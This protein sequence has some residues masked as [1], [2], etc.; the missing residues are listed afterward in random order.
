MSRC[1]GGENTPTRL[2]IPPLLTF[3]HNA[4]PWVCGPRF[5]RISTGLGAQREPVYEAHPLAVDLTTTLMLSIRGP[6][7]SRAVE[8][9]Y[10]LNCRV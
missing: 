9:G 5:L 6:F 7:I 8:G 2:H 1:V 4:A 10:Q 3:P